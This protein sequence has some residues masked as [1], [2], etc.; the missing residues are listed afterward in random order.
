M[1]TRPTVVA[2]LSGPGGAH[3][4]IFDSTAGYLLSETRLH[5]PASGRLQEP[6]S[7]GT[8]IAF[9]CEE[10]EKDIFVLTNGHTLRRLDRRT[11]EVRWGWTAPDQT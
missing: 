7:L 8:T 1:L 5:D 6:E 9:G 4:R 10:K 2:T 11:G 3:F